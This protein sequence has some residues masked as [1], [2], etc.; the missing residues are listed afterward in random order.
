MQ[1]GL[2]PTLSELSV[3]PSWC[4]TAVWRQQFPE[5][6]SLQAD[7]SIDHLKIGHEPSTAVCICPKI[8]APNKLGA[9]KSGKRKKGPLEGG[10]RKRRAPR[11]RVGVKMTKSK[12]HADAEK[13]GDGDGVEGNI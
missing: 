11:K 12:P 6:S 8:S 13:A 3:M 5:G 10:K 7:L 4:S 2:I 9:K 1:S